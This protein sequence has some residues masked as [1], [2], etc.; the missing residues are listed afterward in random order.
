MLHSAE[1]QIRD[2]GYSIGGSQLPA[3]PDGV[4]STTMLDLY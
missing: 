4:E 2:I 1:L 3:V